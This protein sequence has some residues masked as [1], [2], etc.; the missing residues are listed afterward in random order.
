MLQYAVQA[1]QWTEFA[2]RTLVRNFK[3]K[4]L[5]ELSVAAPAS[6]GFP[7]CPPTRRRT[8]RAERSSTV[9]KFGRRFGFSWEAKVNDDLDELSRS[10]AT[11]PSGPAPPR[12]TWPCP[13]W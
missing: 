5:I 7:S 3:P 2:A 11:S 6:T 1:A 13:G 8:T 12:T 4:Q 9:G 10:P